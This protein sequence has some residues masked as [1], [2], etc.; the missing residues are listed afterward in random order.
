MRSLTALTACCLATTSFALAGETRGLGAHEHGVGTFNIAVE[1][2]SVLIELEAPGADI[3]GF[4]HPAESAEDK[5]AITAAKARL[6]DPLSLF[7]PSA[8]AGCA[9]TASEVA[10]IGDDHHDEAHTGHDDAHGHEHGHGHGHAHSHGHDH[11][12]GHGHTSDANHTEFHAEYTL[13][14]ADPGRLERIAFPYFDAFPNA[15]KL[16]VQMIGDNGSA[17][18]DVTRAAPVLEMPGNI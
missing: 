5:A 17:G 4:E 6:A 10:L 16:E 7:V 13:T 3:V 2:T 15:E 11:G 1:G 12:H 14:C 9:V 8:A 18:F